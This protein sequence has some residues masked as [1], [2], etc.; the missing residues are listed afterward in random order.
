MQKYKKED[1]THIQIKMK[2]STDTVLQQL[3]GNN[4][5]TSTKLSQTT[6]KKKKKQM[7]I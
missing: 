2:Q 5:L 3:F 4:F 1:L 7:T 6:K